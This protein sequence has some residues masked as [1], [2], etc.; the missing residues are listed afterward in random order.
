MKQTATVIETKGDTATVEV[1]RQSACEGC[2]MSGACCSCGKTVTATVKN[3]LGALPGD[4]VEVEAPSG[5]IL[6]YALIVFVFPVAAALLSYY[7]S[8]P[9][10][11][12][13]LYP[14]LV[15]LAAFILSFVVIYI[16]ANSRA[17]ENN[18]MEIT[19]ILQDTHRRNNS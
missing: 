13:E 16:F 17:A 12:D 4:I 11:A 1:K 3:K 2:K 18:R 19:R 15:S 14:Y 10:F 9:I 7:L 6:T 5:T 8:V